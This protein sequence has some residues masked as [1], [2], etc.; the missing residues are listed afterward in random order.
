MASKNDVTG[1]TLVSRYN[2]DQYRSNWGR[3]FG[4]KTDT[5]KKEEPQETENKKEENK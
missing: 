4:K 2:S 5:T 1:D 3:I